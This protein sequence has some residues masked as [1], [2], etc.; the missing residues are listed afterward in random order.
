MSQAT[1]T[2]HRDMVKAFLADRADQA[3]RIAVVPGR[4]RSRRVI[5]NAERLD[6]PDEQPAIA[7]I[8]GP[9]VG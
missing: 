4:T 6:S 8:A 5:A 2:E 7:G 1:L 3:L 9:V